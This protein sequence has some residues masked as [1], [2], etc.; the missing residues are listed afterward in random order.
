MQAKMEGIGEIYFEYS[1]YKCK[2]YPQAGLCGQEEYEP[3]TSMNWREAWDFLGKCLP[4]DDVEAGGGVGVGT[5]APTP[6]ASE[7]VTEAPTPAVIELPTYSP[8]ISPTINIIPPTNPPA[9]TTPPTVV[10]DTPTP[11][12]S[13]P[14]AFECVDAIK[15]N[16]SIPSKNEQSSGWGRLDYCGPGEITSLTTCPPPHD[17]AGSAYKFQDR[18]F[19]AEGDVTTR[20]EVNAVGSTWDYSKL[21]IEDAMKNNMVNEAA[22]DARDV[23]DNREGNFVLKHVIT[24]FGQVALDVL[25]GPRMEVRGISKRV[26]DSSDTGKRRLL[27]VGDDA[28]DDIFDWS[29]GLQIATMGS[30]DP[31]Q[32]TDIECPLGLMYDTPQNGTC[33][34]FKFILYP[35]DQDQESVDQNYDNLKAAIDSEGK[36]YDAIMELHPETHVTG[37][38]NPGKGIR[39]YDNVPGDEDESGFPL[40]G[41]ILIVIAVLAVPVAV[42]AMYVKGKRIEDRERMSQLAKYEQKRNSKIEKEASGQ[43]SVA[44]TQVVS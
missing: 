17:S 22:Y 25:G 13:P 36:L 19:M 32:V 43:V 10:S 30:M 42:I 41:I 16:E 14:V 3:G 21:D 27:R 44:V 24:G 39:Y 40:W 5:G 26:G 8:T 15:C 23:L 2:P 38:G 29:R 35:D 12:P 20:A 18:V 33:L 37:L 4:D 1:Y 28:V 11:T 9:A 34:N 31:I 7:T 6:A